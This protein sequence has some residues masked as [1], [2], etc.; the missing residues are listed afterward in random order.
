[1]F[2]L[3][4]CTPHWGHVFTVRRL[5]REQHAD[6]MEEFEGYV[7]ICSKNNFPTAAGLASSAAGYACLGEKCDAV[8]ILERVHGYVAEAC[9]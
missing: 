7:H 8:V 1:M 4:D 6:K 2:L 5:C 3:Y 9:H